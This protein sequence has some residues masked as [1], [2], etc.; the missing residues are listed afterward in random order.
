MLINQTGL[1]YLLEISLKSLILK[2]IVFL[3]VIFLKFNL[4]K[5]IQLTFAQVFTV[6]LVLT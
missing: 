3:T 2:D 6:L 4:N 5:L 1:Q